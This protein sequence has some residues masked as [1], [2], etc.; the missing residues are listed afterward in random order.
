MGV[1]LEN[2]NQIVGTADKIHV[3][4]QK[5][6][7]I[8]SCT[9]HFKVEDT[10]Y[11]AF[12]HIE[13]SESMQ[14]VNVAMSI[15]IADYQIW[16][17]RLGHMNNQALMKMPHCT[18]NFPKE[19]YKHKFS[20]EICSG[21]MEGK[22]MSKSFPDSESRAS[23][24][25][26]LIHLDL[27]SLPVDSY[28]KYKY[29]IVFVDDKSSAY[30]I[31]CLKLKSDTSKAITN[32]EALVRVQYKSMICR[33]HIDAGGEFVN[34]NLDDTLKSLGIHIEKSVPYMHQQNGHSECA[35]RSIM[36][37][38]Q[39]LR[40]TVCLPQS[41]WEFCVEHAVHLHNLTPIACL[42]WCTPHQQLKGEK[43]NVTMLRVFGCGTYVYLPKEK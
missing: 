11:W 33:W 36:E 6:K 38:A 10:I 16:H 12:T 32:V 24:N 13:N 22:M 42:K 29:F 40:F 41:W 27:K 8:M 9:P 35:I 20:P 25:F 31:Q 19:I 17:R 34:H 37:K 3:I 15:H 7:T 18:T 14:L 26:E 5:G 23:K 1:F 21:C 30:W 28:H 39:A 43:P 4:N 2:K